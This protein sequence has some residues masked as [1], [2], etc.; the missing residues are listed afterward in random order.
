MCVCVL[1]SKC[2]LKILN[3]YFICMYMTI[4]KY[5]PISN[6]I[7][8]IYLYIEKTYNDL[9]DLIIVNILPI[10]VTVKFHI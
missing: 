3:Y 10:Y 6:N 5:I 9:L 7:L 4:S 8:M 2:Q 1:T